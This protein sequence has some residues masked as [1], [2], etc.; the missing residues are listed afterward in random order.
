MKDEDSEEDAALVEA[1]REAN[2]LM[3]GERDRNV[4]SWRRCSIMKNDMRDRL[5]VGTTR[6]T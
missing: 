4:L 3:G 6:V 2:G 1:L 5:V